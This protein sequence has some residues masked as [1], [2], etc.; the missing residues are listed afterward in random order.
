[1]SS[2]KMLIGVVIVGLCLIIVMILFLR[3]KDRKKKKVSFKSIPNKASEN[4]SGKRSEE[5][6]NIISEP[7]IFPHNRNVG[8]ITGRPW[9][10]A[11][12]CDKSVL[13][14]IQQLEVDYGSKMPNDCPCT[15]FVRAP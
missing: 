13:Y 5:N 11:N 4:S 9:E 6:T 2:K 12:L 3:K 8:I 14:P 7:Y 15:E 1:M 10:S